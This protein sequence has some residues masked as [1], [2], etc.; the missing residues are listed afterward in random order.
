MNKFEQNILDLEIIKFLEK[1]VIE[2]CY[3]EKE[4]FISNVFLRQ[5][6][7]GSYR[8]IL[9]LKKFNEFVAYHKFKMD[10]LESV[11]QLVTPDCFMASID[12]KDAYYTV[13]VAPEHRKYLRF[14]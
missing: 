10:T 11:I 6:K 2:E 1:G 5:K 8:M 12:L 9:N 14:S 3:N 4:E 7:D 13:S